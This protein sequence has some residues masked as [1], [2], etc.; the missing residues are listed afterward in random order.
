[1]DRRKY[2]LLGIGVLIV[3]LLLWW[4][5]IE[6]VTDILRRARPY[7]FA[8]AVLAYIASLLTWALRW[9]VLLKSLDIDA[10]FK[11]IL[12]AL[13]AGVFINNVTPGAR[14]GGEPVRM[15]YISK[16]TNE[17]Y[18]HVFATVMMDRI[19]DVIPVVFMLLLATLHVYR[20]GSF[21]LTVTLFILDVFFAFVTLATVGILLSERRTK[22]LLY[23]FY[24]QFKRIMPKKAIK[25]E[26]KFVHTVEVSVPQFQ[27]TFKVLMMYKKAF[28]LSL[29]WSFV[30]WFFILLRSYFIFIS[31]NNPVSLMDVMVVQMVGIVIGMF[32]IVPGG[33][34]LTEAI[35]SAVYVL[36]GINKG[37]AVTATILERL[38]SYWIPTFIGAGIMTHFGIKVGRE[39]K[40][41]ENSDN[42]INRKPQE[43]G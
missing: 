42:D 27:E 21:T 12:G 17:S 13:L 29:F 39:R 34:G 35:N 16:R 4:A 19:M 28:L 24:R 5:G 6:E 26:E 3:L 31:I 9:R 10:R 36:L 23:W 8:L 37:I 11:T 40:T 22:G 7:Y 2:S 20:L 32:A 25:Y 30:T 33:A 18:G 38:I 1:M 15:Y 14:G 43:K 41:E